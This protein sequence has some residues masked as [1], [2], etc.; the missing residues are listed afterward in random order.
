MVLDGPFS[1]LAP[2]QIQN[3][4]ACLPKFAPQVI[5]FSKDDLNEVFDEEIVGRVW[6]IESN[7][8]QN[9]AV[10]KEGHLWK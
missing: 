1:K 8:E 10:M 2:D 6:T 3:V 7:D 4:V 9:V 5:L